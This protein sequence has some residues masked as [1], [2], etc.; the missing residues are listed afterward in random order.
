MIIVEN[1]TKFIRARLWT[2]ELPELKYNTIEV[3]KVDIE[4]VNAE[5][6]QQKYLGLELSL[7]RNSSNY[8]LLGV[9]YVPS[10]EK[11]LKV[12]VNVGMSNDVILKN[13]IAQEIDEVHVGI[14]K[15]Y[16]APIIN[17]IQ[18]NINKINIPPGTL[19]FNTGAHGYIG[20]SQTVFLLSTKILINMIHK[21]L[22]SIYEDDLIKVIDESIK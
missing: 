12:K 21:D 14:P 16:A 11:V 3:L 19:L 17:Y 20:S 5:N 13:N 18:E 4:T 22:K 15:E 9:K 2:D 7:S 8:A 1:K 10:K 6:W